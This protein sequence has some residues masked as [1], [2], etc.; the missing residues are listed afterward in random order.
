MT[1]FAV[2]DFTM[3]DSKKIE[4]TSLKKEIFINK[5]KIVQT[6]SVTEY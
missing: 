1:L 5:N 3:L 2:I 6:F 4:V